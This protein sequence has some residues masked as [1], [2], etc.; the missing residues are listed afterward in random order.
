MRSTNVFKNIS[1]GIMSRTL[2]QIL[3]FVVRT[4][5]VYSLPTDFLGINGL[6]TSIFA[7]LNLSELGLSS[8]IVYALYKPLA[9]KDE[10]KIKQL[11]R[12][13]KQA[14][15]IIGGVVATMGVLLLPALPYLAKGGTTSI[16]M[17]AIYLVFLFETVTS[18]WFW[19]YKSSLLVADQKEYI[20]SITKNIMDVIKAII[21]I[22][23]LLV[24]KDYPASSFYVYVVIGIVST[25]ISN[26]LIGKRVYITYPFLKDL[27]Y[28]KLPIVER[29]AILKNVLGLS[30]YRISGTINNAVDALL[31]SSFL[32][33]VVNGIYA[34]YEL[35]IS[36]VN[37]LIWIIVTS[38]IPSVGNINFTE[39]NEKKYFLFKCIGLALFWVYGFCGIS[40]WVLLNPF[41]GGVWLNDSFL[42]SEKAV[43]VLFINFIT[44]GM[45][46]VF[47]IFVE[48]TGQFSRR[49]WAS[50]ASAVINVILSIILLKVTNWGIGGVVLA[51]VCARIIVVVPAYIK[52]I[53]KDV[54]SKNIGKF[55]IMYIGTMGLTLITGL[56]VKGIVLTFEGDNLLFFLIKAL[57]CVF[58]V[59]VS[60]F[61]IFRKTKE[62]VYLMDVVKLVMTKI[63]NRK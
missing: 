5:F 60:W 9:Q 22:I 53:S 15:T 23:F 8:A 12:F 35:I 33:L 36:T 19:A 6:F 39:N 14:Y 55:W 2:T 29:N 25:I 47:S 16:N 50:I 49:G 38:L 28:E 3:G 44:G 42:L 63:K 51:T 31:I 48:A 41:I 13:Y 58:C 4:I 1:I 52:I 11:V 46:T 20:I 61:L 45:L 59:N 56:G 30:A 17:Y 62:F 7:F 21:R 24:L 26:W 57:I 40:L 27:E 43:F 18:Y 54:F 32:G 34:N 37:S 10:T